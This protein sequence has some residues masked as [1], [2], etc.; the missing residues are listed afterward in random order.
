MKIESYSFILL[1]VLVNVIS[2]NTIY[3]EDLINTYDISLEINPKN[4]MIEAEIILALNLSNISQDTMVFYLHG[5]LSII[6][7]ESNQPLDFN[8]LQDQ[9]CPYF[10]MENARPLRII[11]NQEYNRDPIIRIKYQ[12]LLKDIAWNT[13]NMLTTEWIEL[14]SFSAWFPFNPEYGDFRYKVQ[15]SIEEGYNVSGMGEIE[16]KADG[17]WEIIQDYPVSDIVLVA[18]RE[19]KTMNYVDDQYQIRIDYVLMKD[20]EVEALVE[21]VKFILQLYNRWF[22]ASSERYTIVIVPPF[23]DR[24]SYF[25]RGFIALLQP[26]PGLESGITTFQLLAHELAHD[27]WSGANTN[28]WEDWLNESF[29]E[30]SCLMAIR[31]KFGNEIFK[32]WIDYKTFASKNAEPVIGCGESIRTSYSTRY[33][34]GPVA[35]NYLEIMLGK[36]KF[37]EVLRGINESN[38]TT[39]DELLDKLE[40]ATSLQTKEQ[41]EDELKK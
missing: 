41:F 39:T 30:Y 32:D 9:E 2:I 1:A 13:T 31:E 23:P 38:V 16:E 10:Y 29:A 40:E 36:E 33:D 26:V 8:F 20:E 17:K 14:G 37:I 21:D 5:E 4:Q 15:V 3:G 27:W 22:H 24:G 25:R 19:L 28:N 6:S 34:K 12:G 18:S 7:I 35:L 11:L